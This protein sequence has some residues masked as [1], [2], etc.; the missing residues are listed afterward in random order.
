MTRPNDTAHCAPGAPPVRS[1]AFMEHALSRWGDAVYRV[2]L[3]QMRS[4][5]DAQD[6]AQDVFLRLLNDGTAFR[7]DEHLKAWLLRVTVNRCNELHR[8]A[9]RRRASAS[10]DL[11]RV[12]E[13]RTD[14][15]N[16]TR[17][18]ADDAPESLR[19]SPVWEAV[20]SLPAEQRLVIHLHCIEGYPA[21]EI[22]RFLRVSPSTVR[23]RLHRARKKLAA[24]LGL[25]S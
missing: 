25:D 22:A 15:A 18:S 14:D 1:E 11:A 17:A 9:W 24:V 23:T 13:E 12:L 10:D 5:H 20:Q 4:P 6:V 2:A 16:G 19:T 8:S 7:D 3:N 21:E